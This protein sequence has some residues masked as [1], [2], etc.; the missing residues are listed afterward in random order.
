MVDP[1]AVEDVGSGG[2]TGHSGGAF[3]GGVPNSAADDEAE[4]VVVGTAAGSMNLRG[5]G[6]EIATS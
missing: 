1:A 5:A 4:D 2:I 3:R 6:H